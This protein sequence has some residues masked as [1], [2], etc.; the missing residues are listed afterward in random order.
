M[1][2][3][4]PVVATDGGGTSE[5][6]IDGI[7]GFLVAP[8]RPETLAEKIELLL[9]RPDL[10][11]AFGEAGRQRIRARFSL[12]QLVDGTLQVYRSVLEGATQPLYPAKRKANQA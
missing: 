9:E 1:A 7:T 5:L 4:K 3:G 12:Q 8:Q 11:R 10:S 2:L 6:V